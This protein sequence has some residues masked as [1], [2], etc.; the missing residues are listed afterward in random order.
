MEQETSFHNSAVVVT[1]KWKPCENSFQ[2]KDLQLQREH[3]ILRIIGERV[4][5]GEGGATDAW[6]WKAVENQERGISQQ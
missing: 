1:Q 6:D 5:N 2:I 3:L 4:E